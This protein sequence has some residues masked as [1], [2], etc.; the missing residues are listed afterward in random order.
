MAVVDLRRAQRHRVADFQVVGNEARC[1]LLLL[2]GVDQSCV[3]MG[4]AAQLFGYRL[5]APIQRWRRAALRGI[6][7]A[8]A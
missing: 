6:E 8:I 3:V 2:R 7:I 1:A 5:Q 4:A